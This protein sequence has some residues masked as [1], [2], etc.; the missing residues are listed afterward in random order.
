[1]ETTTTG[2]NDLAAAE[3]GDA[4]RSIGGDDEAASR[5]AGQIARAVD[6]VNKA[7]RDAVGKWEQL[8]NDDI[9]NPAGIARQLAELPTNIT[10]ATES[11]LKQA[12]AALDIVADLHE[13]AVLRHDGR[14]DAALRW[15]LD[16]FLA[17]TKPDTAAATLVELAADPRFA[18]F[19]AGSAG[20]SL[21]ARYRLKDSDV[22]RRVAL[23]TLAA[24]GSEDQRRRSEALASIGKMRRVLGLARG[25]RDHAIEHVKRAPAPKSAA[26]F[27]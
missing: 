27:S 25:G 12:E 17:G 22:F 5:W 14:N 2:L 26:L 20:A 15:E 24:R 13:A 11:K 6:E 23:E 21:V 8:N 7:A 9:S 3:L 18:T 4:T 1:M 19:L 16:N 10:V